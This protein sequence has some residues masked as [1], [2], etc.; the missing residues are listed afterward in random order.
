MEDKRET[1][2][3]AMEDKHE[4]YQRD[5]ED[6][7][8]TRQQAPEDKRETCGPLE[9]SRHRKVDGRALILYTAAI[10]KHDKE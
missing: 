6:K 7:R 4:T 8:E 3:Q 1:R 10:A 5:K 9:L 2:L